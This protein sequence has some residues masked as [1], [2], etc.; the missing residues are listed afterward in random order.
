[1][2][3]AAAVTHAAD[4]ERLPAVTARPTWHDT[5]MPPAPARLVGRHRELA[6]LRD[7]LDEVRAGTGRTVVVAGEAGIGKTRLVEELTSSAEDVVVLTGQ[8]ADSGSGPVPYAAL[9]GILHDIVGERG[10]ERTLAAAGPASGALSAVAPGL[11]QADGDPGAERVPEVVAALVT[12]LA[13]D[14]PVL[15]VVEDL[16]WSDDVT[17]ALTIRLARAMTPGLL[18]VLTYRSDDVG[19]D[20]PWRPAMAELDRGRVV[21]RVDLRRLGENEV[22]AMA[23]DLVG[24]VPDTA[25]LTDLVERSEGVPFYVEELAGALDGSDLPESLRDILLLRYWRLSR[26]AQALCRVVAAAGPRVWYDVLDDVLTDAGYDDGNGLDDAAREAVES[27]VLVA[28]AER[29]QFRHALMQEAVY[30][31]LLPGERRRLHIA[32]AKALT[33]ALSRRARSVAKLSRIADHW[34]RA[35]VLDNALAAAVEG[36][37][38]AIAGAAI[39]AA[40]RLG[41]RALELWEQVPDAQTVAGMPHHELLRRVADAARR[42]SRSQRA[43]V[44]ARQALDEWPVDDPVGMARML[45]DAALC[46][47]HAGTDEGPL[48]VDKA[49]GLVEPG[50]DDAVRAELLVRKARY[51]GLDGEVEEAIEV[52]RAAYR[53]ALAEG[54]TTLASIALNHSGTSKHSLGDPVGSEEITEARRL[55]GTD[56][57]GLSKYYINGSN[58]HLIDGDWARALAETEQGIEV[59]RGLGAL[60]M[61]TIWVEMNRA[62]ALVGLG[63]WAEAAAFYEQRI[64]LTHDSTAA[65]HLQMQSTWLMLWRGQVADAAREARRRASFWNRFCALEEQIRMRVTMLNAQIALAQGQVRTAHDIV[66]AFVTTCHRAPYLMEPLALVAHTV[67][68]LRATGATV[69]EAPYRAAL[70]RCAHWPTYPMWAATFDAELGTGRWADVLDHPGG[71]A[72]AYVYARYR[73]G[74]ALLESG[75]RSASRTVLTDALIESD[76]VG[77]GLISGWIMDLL[78]RAGLDA[79]VRDLLADAEAAAAST[80]S[81]TSVPSPSPA[82]GADDGPRASVEDSEPRPPS[83]TEPLTARERQV[84]NLVAD[85]LT[86]AQ[87]AR[88]LFISPKTASVHVSAILRK[89][90]VSTRTE[91]AL[92]LRR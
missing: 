45:G 79:G 52:A 53:M 74:R 82:S 91:A 1:M 66:T 46:A 18:L 43:L 13:A 26:E 3:P 11:V 48:F 35:G 40:V 55:A 36:L 90:G 56:W 32:Y 71:P 41:K 25:F 64:P 92:H 78:V 2:T 54:L 7:A 86:N 75:D 72:H 20:H 4:P 59:A 27:S 83:S 31:E 37:G 63:R 69:D 19:R 9:T 47:G 70:A 62:E 33:T 28:T 88:R 8:C 10:L 5:T 65:V 61:S 15:V 34:W 51:L 23:G 16:H 6:D 76:R 81:V 14:R 21:T 57:E 12:G 89:L 50:R 44:L 30:S 68:G 22:R 80:T 29:Y 39:S 17:R 49:L 58:T 77:T 84:L 42:S 85:G 73:E 67:A 38:A 24:Q 87:I 60:E